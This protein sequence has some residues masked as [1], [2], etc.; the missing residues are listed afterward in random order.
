MKSVIMQLPLKMNTDRTKIRI[1]NNKTFILLLYNDN[2]S[3]FVTFNRL[4][5][6]NDF[7]LSL[8]IF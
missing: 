5:F 2:V 7:F 4:T 6:F 3:H 8:H 1:N